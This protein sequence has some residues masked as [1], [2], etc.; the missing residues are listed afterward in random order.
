MRFRKR[1]RGG[2]T[3]SRLTLKRHIFNMRAPAKLFNAI[4]GNAMNDKNGEFK[5]ERLLK[6]LAKIH[7]SETFNDL[8]DMDFCRLWGVGVCS[9]CKIRFFLTK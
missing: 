2:A 1:L 3:S 9:K 5:Q 7:I 6:R 4:R 8:V